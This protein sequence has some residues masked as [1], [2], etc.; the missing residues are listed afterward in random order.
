MT[1][2]VIVNSLENEKVPLLLSSKSV[3]KSSDLLLK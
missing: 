3:L 2:E 1:D